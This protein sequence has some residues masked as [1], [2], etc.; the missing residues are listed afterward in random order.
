MSAENSIYD[1]IVVGTG[2]GGMSA[3]VVAARGGLKVLMI[4]LK[5]L[6]F[7]MVRPLEGLLVELIMGVW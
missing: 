5:P 1:V 6:V 7:I 4:I 2:A 3:A